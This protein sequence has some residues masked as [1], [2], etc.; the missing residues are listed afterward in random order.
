M[1][2]MFD[3]GDQWEFKIRREPDQETNELGLLKSGG[4]PV[5]NQYSVWD[6]E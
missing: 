2:F 3:F 4:S 6:E 5:P 1:V